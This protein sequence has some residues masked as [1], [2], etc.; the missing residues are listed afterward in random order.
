MIAKK[1]IV[2]IVFL[3]PALECSVSH[4][5]N[6]AATMLPR[7][8]FKTV[9]EFKT[10]FYEKQT[11]AN[12]V[13]RLQ[14]LPYRTLAVDPTKILPGSIV[15]VPQAYGVALPSGEIHDGF[16]FAHETRRAAGDTLWFY[17][18]EELRSDNAFTRSPGFRR[19]P[20]CEAHVV[21]EPVAGALRLRYREAFETKPEP[22]L[23][24]MLAKDIDALLRE[25]SA[26][27]PDFFARLAIYTERAKGTPYK[28]FC[29]GEGP[30][31]KYDRDP[32]IDFSRADCVTFI[33]QMLA[34][35]LSSNYE[36]MFANLQRIR[37]KNGEIG[38]TT[39]NH[40]THADWIPSNAW[41][42]HDATAEIGGALCADMT[43]V[44]D[45]PAFF[46]KLGVPE[47]ELRNVPGPQTM[48]I[49]YVP[50]ENL[51]KIK[52][53]LQS[54][55]IASIVQKMPGIFSA[56]TGFIMRD[57]YGNVLLRHASS[58]K[59]T[60]QVTDEYFDEVIEQLRSSTSRVGMA[61]VRIKTNVQ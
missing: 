10:G 5:Q 3:M 41:L 24:A 40:Y 51:P 39:R 14:P 42:L 6:A 1:H 57:E 38:F 47:E 12:G 21:S 45:R 61:F 20:L 43:K 11:A 44:I 35:A 58:R 19:H 26:A 28:L 50:T 59:E 48:T 27:Q 29:L 34:L 46:R 55:D 30:T 32:L 7:T 13:T 9:G 25:V 56:H 49:K 17:V 4:A 36:Q 31:A 8:A 16:F 23:Y 60:N 52:D 53:R 18:G 54:G 37:Y 22:P 2:L 33:E 15:F